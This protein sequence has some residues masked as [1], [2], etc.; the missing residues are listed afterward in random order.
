MA[1][2]VV[3][4]AT[5]ALKP[6]VEKLA[7]ALG[8]EYQRFKGVRGEIQSLTEEL[9]AMHRFLLKMSE[10]EDPD[11][12][13]KAWMNEVRE[14][15][16]DME[17]S[18]DEF[19]IR[20]EANPTNPHGFMDKCKNIVTK[21][22]TRKKIAKAIDK[23]KVQIKEVGERNTRYKN[24]ATINNTSNKSVDP[25]AL[26]IFEDASKMLVGIG[27]PKGE[28]VELLKKKEHESSRKTK[29]VSIVGSGGLGKTTLANQVYKELK[30]TFE[31]GAFLSV[32]RSPDMTKILRIILSDVSNQPY[33]NT[34]AGSPQQLIGEIRKH[35]EDKRYLIV[36]DDVWKE[37]T[38]KTINYALIRNEKD[39]RIITTTRMYGV[40]KA[41]CSSDCD[42]VHKMKALDHWDSRKLFLKRL[43]GAEGQCP[44]QLVNI[45]EKIL[46]KCD[47]VPLAIIS[48]AGLLAN[49]PKREDEWDQVHNSIGRGLGK[50]P[51]AQSM[52]QILSLSYFDLPHHL[53]TCLLY[54]SIFPEDSVIA[55]GRLVRRWI[56]E[57][58]IQEEQGNTTLYELGERCFN[59]LINRN[60]IQARKVNVYG[61]VTACQIHDTI[62]DFV[63]LKSEE[64]NFVTL[65]GDDYQMPSPRSNKVRRLSLHVSGEEKV[66][67]PTELDLSHVRSVTV[68]NYSVELPSWTKFHFLRVLD[69]QGCR[70]VESNHLAAIG[71]LFQLKYLN[72]R[73]TGVDE[74][75]EQIR[76]LQYLETLELK[77]SK[78]TTLPASIVELQRLVYLGVDEEVKLPNGVGSMTA[79]EDLDCVDIFKQSIEFMRELEQLKNIRRVSL[80]LSSSSCCDGT[81]FQVA[82]IL[83][84]G[85]LPALVFLQ[86]L[87]MS[88]SFEVTR[89]TIRGCDGFCRLREFVF[90]CNNV[91][92]MFEVG[93][94]PSLERLTLMFSFTSLKIDQLLVSSGEIPFGIKYLS[95]LDRLY[96]VV[97]YDMD[98]ICHW[99]KK[100]IVQMK[101]KGFTSAKKVA[102]MVYTLAV[103][104]CSL[105]VAKLRQ[106]P[107]TGATRASEIMVRNNP[108]L[109]LCH[110]GL[111][112][113][114]DHR[115][116]P[117][118]PGPQLY[119]MRN[120]IKTLLH[121]KE[122]P[123]VLAIE[124]KVLFSS[125]IRTWLED[126]TSDTISLHL[127]QESAYTATVAF[128]EHT[129][130]GGYLY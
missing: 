9:D 30:N 65:F 76:K 43:F 25:R 24:P 22:K 32:S 127:I 128:L 113:T 26:T 14:L 20:V 74:I 126:D 51:D 1:E 46:G 64:E 111:W 69:L 70:Q 89:L 108:Q 62:L 119:L 109:Q 67:M 68:F 100:K 55:K 52:M 82:D 101:K 114:A 87:V 12:Q 47:G 53:K 123:D 44:P 91:T 96:S 93:A 95:S 90:V 83:V 23:L 98:F 125:I 72:L 28:L 115:R 75:P 57:G 31:C 19:M 104:T 3:S 110:R 13:D 118:Y 61:Q 27:Q 29:V 45:S 124:D 59:E 58:F 48:I 6:L 21:L 37:E 106:H 94:M 116:I 40:A 18:L 103:V 80:L 8:E 38:W 33:R 11:V 85:R 99:I 97:S 34:E 121:C 2:L 84:L 79:L 117:N 78:V 129:W 122:L 15:S 41:C 39:S 107:S 130:P 112:E 7:A 63:I 81:K 49:K 16:Y 77:K 60:L 42:F 66:S 88:E 86:L 56:A 92:V 73:E 4:A 36:I 17:D 50:H 5:G 120:K 35:L 54:L 71:D 102:D 105:L 10:V